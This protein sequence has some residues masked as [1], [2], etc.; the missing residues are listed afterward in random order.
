VSTRWIVLKFGGTSVSTEERWRTIADL[1]AG[2]IAD[3]LKPVVVCSA[4]SGIS[5]Q[6]EAL[7]TLAV[8]GRHEEALAAI[9]QRHLE[10]GEGLGID[11]ARLLADDSPHRCCARPDR[12]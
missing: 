7:L 11:A 10:L 1:T 3:G 9:R 2:R 6:L 4:L 5:N 12:L 8:A